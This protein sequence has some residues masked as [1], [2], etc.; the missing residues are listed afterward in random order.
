MKKLFFSVIYTLVATT[1]LPV[2]A[3]GYE[4]FD[5][6][7]SNM[8]TEGTT[9]ELVLNAGEDG[10]EYISEMADKSKLARFSVEPAA[11][12]FGIDPTEQFSSIPDHSVLA[13]RQ[14]IA[15]DQIASVRNYLSFT[16]DKIENITWVR[17]KAKNVV[18]YIAI[19]AGERDGTIW[20]R[21]QAEARR[22]I[23]LNIG[24]IVLNIDGEIYRIQVDPQYRQISSIR[25]S[26]GI[27]RR[28]IGYTE[29]IDIPISGSPQIMEVLHQ[30]P[31]SNNTAVRLRGHN[32][33]VDFNISSSSKNALS[34]VLQYYEAT[35]MALQ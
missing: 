12:S 15:I 21:L 10:T 28:I 9:E 16:T 26:R 17:A 27:A 8:G 34:I 30:I 19:Y 3:S 6:L 2:L 35:R 32:G 25:E 20:L 18:P 24:Q 5:E 22:T 23:L 14:D 29:K 33:S 11:R 13:T 7:V 31:S 1:L 4:T